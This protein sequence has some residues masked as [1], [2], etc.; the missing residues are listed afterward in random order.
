MKRG[1][2]R[3]SGIPQKLRV[4]VCEREKEDGV[5]A[6]RQRK[7]EKEENW[8]S[9]RPLGH[10]DS[11]CSSHDQSHAVSGRLD[12]LPLLLAVVRRQGEARKEAKKNGMNQFNQLLCE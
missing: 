4:S 10:H 2:G 6:G 5:E 1:G 11:A 12:S 8:K 9:P 3:G 7:R